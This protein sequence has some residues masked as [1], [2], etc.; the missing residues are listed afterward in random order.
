G[1]AVMGVTIATTII[2]LIAVISR[3]ATRLGIVR[4]A[5]VDDI[6]IGIAWLF[7]VATTVTMV[8]QVKHGMGRHQYDLSE[9]D[10]LAQLKPFWVSVIVYNLSISSAKF[11]ILF[12]YLRI[13]PQQRFRQACYTLMAVVGI[14]SCW[15]FFSAV[16]AC[17]PISFFWNP[18]QEGHCLNR[19]A[20]WFANAGMNIVTDVATALLPLPV[21]KSLELPPRQKHVLLVIFALGG[22]TCI[23]S[24]LRLYSLYV[25]SAT[26]DISWNNPLAAIW[27]SVEI[28]TGILCSC[29]P[30]LKGCVTRF[31]PNLF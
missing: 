5:G 12:Q 24:I 7:S 31:F 1:D 16:F 2:S 18:M 22:F 8:L 29:L 9:H 6:F 27:S 30:T 17:S 28:N 21:L 11:S 4:N 3:L 13:F 10:Q 20:V 14:Y 26:T 19:F 23:V 15:T 25:I